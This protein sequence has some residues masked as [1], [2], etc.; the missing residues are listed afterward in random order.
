MCWGWEV[1]GRL[2]SLSKIEKKKKKL[3]DADKS[4]AIAEGRGARAVAGSTGGR[5][6]GGRR[7][8]LGR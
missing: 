3:G 2:W 6:G 1:L 5:E 8:D 7:R 4:V